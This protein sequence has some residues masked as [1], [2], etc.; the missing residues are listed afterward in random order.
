ME[1]LCIVRMHCPDSIDW[2]FFPEQWYYEWIGC[3]ET[4]SIRKYEYVDACKRQK[5][6]IELQSVILYIKKRIW[7]L[8]IF[9]RRQKFKNV[10]NSWKQ[11]NLSHDCKST[12][13]IQS[14]EV[15]TPRLRRPCRPCIHRQTERH[16]IQFNKAPMAP[17]HSCWW[18]CEDLRTN[19]NK[20]RF[21]LVYEDLHRPVEEMDALQIGNCACLQECSWRRIFKRRRLGFPLK[22]FER[23]FENCLD[24][25]W[26][27]FLLASYAGSLKYNW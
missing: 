22:T 12:N 16:C 3:T 10:L 15:G 9:G 11:S 13:T 20:S 6:K 4:S 21:V 18:L 5:F 26:E 2:G 23:I 17:M 1:A 19:S 14:K 7:F 25:R 27:L 24:W 8:V